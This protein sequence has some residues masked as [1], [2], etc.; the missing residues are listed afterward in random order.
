MAYPTVNSPTRLEALTLASQ[1]EKYLMRA[2]QLGVTEGGEMAPSLRPVIEALHHVLAGGD[3]AVD[4][5]VRGNPD[6]VRELNETLQRGVEESKTIND[7]VGFYLT[8]T[9]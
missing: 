1:L 5:K 4:V 8:A 3:V 7:K 9:F 2:N 6:I